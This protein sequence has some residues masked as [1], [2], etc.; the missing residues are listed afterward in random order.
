MYFDVSAFARFG[1]V[2][3]LHARARCWRS[4]PS[5]A[6]T[7]TTRNKR[8][9]L[10]FVL[11]QP[12]LDDE[13][14]WES[15]WGPGRPGLAHRVLGARPARARH[16]HRPARRRRRPDLPAPRVRARRSRRP[17]PASRSSATGCTRRWCAWTARRCRSRSATSSSSPTCCKQWDP[18]AIRL[19]LVEDHYRDAWEWDDTPMPACRRAARA[20]A[21]GGRRATARSTR[22]GPRSTTTSTRRR[23]SPPSTRPLP[24][25]E[26]VAAAAASS[27][28]TSLT[29]ESR[30]TPGRRVDEARRSWADRG[31]DR[32]STGSS[33]PWPRPSCAPVVPLP[34]AIE[35]RRA[36]STSR[37]RARRSLPNHIVGA[38][39]ASSCR[40]SCRGGSRSSARPSTWTTGRRSTSSRRWG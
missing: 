2:S 23:P 12:S 14:S 33:T 4:P 31:A 9:P 24:P 36:S 26:G 16:D 1:S 35:R 7:S 30:P 28:S 29:A 6:A 38:R 13:P 21:G 25:V 22:C 10:D 17:P 37:R 11:W 32:T 8:D 40:S 15:L 27:A 39:L 20:V 34:V 19:L 18:M 3:P 5:G